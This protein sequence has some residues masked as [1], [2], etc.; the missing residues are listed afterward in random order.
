[1]GKIVDPKLYGWSEEMINKKFI[2]IA[3]L[4]VLADKIQTIK[5]ANVLK[6]FFKNFPVDFYFKVSFDK[7]NR[8][9][10]ESFR[11]LGLEEGV[12]IFK[13]LRDEVGVKILTDVHETYQVD[14]NGY[15]DH[16]ADTWHASLLE[17]PQLTTPIAYM[18]SF[19]REPFPRKG[20]PLDPA[21]FGNG[22]YFRYYN[23]TRWTVPYP[24]L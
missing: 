2:V 8:T 7:A 18:T 21:F 9:K 13:E 6:E 4:C 22:D 17:I 12:K 16:A 3:G 24:T 11:G 5:H 10:D 1:M 15:P 20:P 14:F 19:P 23:T